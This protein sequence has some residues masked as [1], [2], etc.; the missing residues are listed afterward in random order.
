MDA[1]RAIE[2]AVWD[3]GV[4]GDSCA[5]LAAQVLEALNAAGYELTAKDGAA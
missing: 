5:F 1:R 3:W 4:Q 2:R